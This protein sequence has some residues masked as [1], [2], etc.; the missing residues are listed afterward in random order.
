VS[1]FTGYWSVVQADSGDSDDWAFHS[2]TYLL[3]SW[4]GA[5]RGPSARAA[6]FSGCSGTMQFLSRVACSG[7]W[8]VLQSVC[9]SV[10]LSVCP[11]P[12]AQNQAP[13]EGDAMT[14]LRHGPYVISAPPWIFVPPSGKKLYSFSF[15]HIFHQITAL[16]I[17]IFD[18]GA[19]GVHHKGA[20]KNWSSWN[21][22][23]YPGEPVPEGKANLDFTEASGIS[24][25][26][27]KQSAPRSTPTPN[28]LFFTQVNPPDPQHFCAPSRKSTHALERLRWPLFK[29]VHLWLRLLYNTVRQKKNQ[30]SFVRVSVNTWQKLVIFSYILRS[31]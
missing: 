10:C 11:K 18:F 7:H 9:L 20:P 19:S 1:E 4:H 3:F 21:L 25:T 15:I 14:L 22:L 24:W 31:V 27:C 13:S 8:A 16:W 30:F 6:S 26:I 28:H 17:L 2:F 12:V 5:S 29:T 23:Y